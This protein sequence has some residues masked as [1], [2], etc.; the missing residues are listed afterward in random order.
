MTHRTIWLVWEIQI[1]DIGKDKVQLQDLRVIASSL[2]KAR[3]YKKVFVQDRKDW[4]DKDTW[5]EIEER[6]LDH[7]FGYQDLKRYVSR[8]RNET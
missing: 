2:K 6:E 4:N 3:Q 7:A 1:L 8:N 5:F